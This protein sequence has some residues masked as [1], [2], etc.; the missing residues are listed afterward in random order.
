MTKCSPSPPLHPHPPRVWEVF[1]SAVAKS[2]LPPREL[3]AV[4]SCWGRAGVPLSPQSWAWDDSGWHGKLFFLPNLCMV[5]TPYCVVIDLSTVENIIFPCRPYSARSEGSCNMQGCFLKQLKENAAWA[6]IQVF[7]L[8]L[9]LVL[10]CKTGASF[11]FS[12]IPRAPAANRSPWLG[13]SLWKKTAGT[14]ELL[15]RTACLGRQWSFCPVLWCHI[16]T[17]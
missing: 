13:F 10:P 5:L 16:S 3:K 12:Q 2:C 15:G 1:S 8:G 7:F 14:S 9:F 11:N 4:A 17:L 6:G